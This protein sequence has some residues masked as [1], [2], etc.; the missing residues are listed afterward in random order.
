[1]QVFFYWKLL[2]NLIGQ[3]YILIYFR[4]AI[5]MAEWPG[6]VSCHDNPAQMFNAVLPVK[7]WSRGCGLPGQHLGRMDY[8][9]TMIAEKIPFMGAAAC[10]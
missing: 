2:K 4:F 5:Y 6:P 10:T 9:D 3:A 8:T 1:M 7:D